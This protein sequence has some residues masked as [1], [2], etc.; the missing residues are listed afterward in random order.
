V[1]AQPSALQQPNIPAHRL[2]IP[3]RPAHNGIARYRLQVVASSVADAVMSAGGLI[4]DRAMAG[5]DVTV[6]VDGNV[7][8]VPVRIL[9]ARVG[10]LWAGPGRPSEAPRPQVLAVAADVLIESEPVRR[11]VLAA[12]DGAATDILLWGRRHP[13]IRKCT[14]VPVRHRPSAAAHVFKSHALAAGEACGTGLAE[15][16]FYSLT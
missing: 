8:D 2:T 9:G 1:A 10:K 13:P 4:F 12:R 7:D 15:E 5:W 11:L 16:A 6:V 3:P 14:F